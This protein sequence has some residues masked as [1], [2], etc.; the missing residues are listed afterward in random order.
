M[1][2]GGGVTFAVNTLIGRREEAMLELCAR[3][4]ASSMAE[5][6]CSKPLLMA[7][8]LRQHTSESVKPILDTIEEHKV[9]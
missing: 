8:A 2:L 1:A 7:I 9:W 5:K 6:G 3:R 4:V